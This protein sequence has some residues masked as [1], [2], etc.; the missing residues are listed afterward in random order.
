MRNTFLCR[1]GYVMLLACFAVK[2]QAQEVL[3]RDTVVRMDGNVR[4]QQARFP[5]SGAAFMESGI[6]GVS[7]EGERADSIRPRG[8][9]WLP[10]LY[11]DG[12]VA[13]YPAGF[14]GGYMGLWNLHEG[15]N[16]G[17]SMSVSASFGRNRFPGVGFGTGISAMYVHR[18]TERLVLAAGGFYDRLSWGGLNENRLG[19]NVLMGYQLTDRVSLYAY[20]SKSFIPSRNHRIPFASMPWMDDFSSRLGAMVHIK[21]SDAVSVSV[22]LE[23]NRR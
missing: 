12:T 22:S 7:E 5:D 9:G 3:S 14:H 20:G 6:E 2:G 11:S 19:V 23:E 4:G 16:A 17:L 15:F 10:S 1:W 18:L 21:V 8:L 13:Y